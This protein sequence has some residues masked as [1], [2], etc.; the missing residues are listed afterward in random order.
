MICAALYYGFLAIFATR[1]PSA[2]V[3]NIG[4]TA[5]FWLL[6]ALL[7]LNTAVCLWRRTRSVLREVGAQPMADRDRPCWRHA[8]GDDASPEDVAGRLRALGY[9]RT[10]RHGET[11][12][13]VRRRFGALGTL[14]FHLAFFPVSAG[15]LLTFAF[16]SEATATIAV[17]ESFTGAGEQLRGGTS[18]SDA[19][20][21]FRLERLEPAFWRDQ[22]LFT[23]LAADVSLEDGE[24]ARLE[25]NRP[26]WLGWG[27]FLRLTGFG[28][29][30]VYELLDWGGRLQSA[31][32]VKLSVFPPG[33]R[34]YF[35]LPG[36]P[37]RVHL[38]VHPNAELED[39]MVV[40]RS[41]ELA[42]PL[43][44]ARVSRG[45]LTVGQGAFRLG[46][47][48]EFE[49][50]R[51]RF[52]RIEYFGEFTLLEDPGAPL[53]LLGFLFALGGLVL[54]A[55]GRRAE[56]QWRPGPGGRGGELLG[57]GE[58]EPPPEE[59]S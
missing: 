22:L 49:E 55:F 45:K 23:S 7:L 59:V 9:R 1:S 2:I 44:L 17:G 11:L 12:L 39:G 13:A 46:E 31:G 52:P 20:P 19:A 34:D 14:A 25:I 51:L 38:E 36:L 42:R 4:G 57:F 54:R 26:L 47:D 43:L 8:L 48:L 32:V 3:G 40:N 53:L 56:V 58:A 21:R 28:Y 35:N 30:P 41:M 16:R 10:A 15:F 24:R 33:Q 50:L 18:A 6:Y 27:R 29:A 37:H 5:P